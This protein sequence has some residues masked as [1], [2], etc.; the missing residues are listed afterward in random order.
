M[1]SA[2]AKREREN[3]KLRRGGKGYAYPDHGSITLI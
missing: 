2:I 3:D 1:K